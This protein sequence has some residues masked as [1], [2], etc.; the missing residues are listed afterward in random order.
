MRDVDL[1]GMMANSKNSLTLMDT[2]TRAT[3]N[4]PTREGRFP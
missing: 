4:G 3:K 2:L 1:A